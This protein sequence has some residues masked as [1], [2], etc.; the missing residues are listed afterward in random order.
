[1]WHVVL[2]TLGLQTI[3][4]VVLIRSWVWSD[5]VWVQW[6]LLK[7]SFQ[8]TMGIIVSHACLMN[9]SYLQKNKYLKDDHLCKMSMLTCGDG[10]LDDA[11]PRQTFSSITVHSVRSS[12]YQNWLTAQRP[13]GSWYSFQSLP[14]MPRWTSKKIWRYPERP[15]K[16]ISNQQ[17]KG[18]WF[19]RCSM[20]PSLK[21]KN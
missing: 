21:K 17:R 12:S 9:S 4:V 18:P 2:R 5:S 19:W 14:V 16:W 1:M 3:L 10:Q 8:Q 20:F 13:V 7:K 6:K 11:N 15:T